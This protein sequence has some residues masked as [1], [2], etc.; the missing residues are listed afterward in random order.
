MNMVDPYILPAAAERPREQPV[1]DRSVHFENP[2]P[3]AVPENQILLQ[4]APV[5]YASPTPILK[6]GDTPYSTPRYV[7]PVY[8]S[9]G[10]QYTAYGRPFEN[11]YAHGSSNEAA[12][13][14]GLHQ[15]PQSVYDLPL[16]NISSISTLLR[17]LHDIVLLG[18]P[19][20]YH[21]RLARVRDKADLLPVRNWTIDSTAPYLF[22]PQMQHNIPP[23]SYASVQPHV[24]GAHRQASLGGQL[25][26]PRVQWDRSRDEWESFVFTSTQ[27]WQ[28]LNIIS[29]LL[30]R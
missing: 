20:L 17:S 4:S 26:G 6:A 30:L 1:R 24:T 27:E 23:A 9:P 5:W 8:Q 11:A 29:A 28:T 18:L 16:T 13:S 19:L 14:L 3:S 10:L 22:Q 2:G 7:V 12:S 25:T 15:R 21:R